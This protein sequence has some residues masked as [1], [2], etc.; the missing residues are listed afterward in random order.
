MD[1]P[2]KLNKAKANAKVAKPS[3]SAEVVP[4]KRPFPPALTASTTP[5]QSG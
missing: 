4:L 1:K 3:H 5:T 2:D